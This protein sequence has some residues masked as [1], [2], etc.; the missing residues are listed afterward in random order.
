M[1]LLWF[2]YVQ[3]DEK[4]DGSVMGSLASPEEGSKS[5]HTGDDR[6]DLRFGGNILGSLR[7]TAARLQE[8]NGITPTGELTKT[9][10]PE[11]E[12][13]LAQGLVRI[14]ETVEN[15]MIFF[16]MEGCGGCQTMYPIIKKLQQQEYKIYWVYPRKNQ[17]L[18]RQYKIQKYPTMVIFDNKKVVKK[19]VGPVATKTITNYLNKPQQSSNNS[20]HTDYDFISGLL[21][22]RLW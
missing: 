4:I 5:K 15:Y 12:K 11:R 20:D 13:I 8:Y 2:T 17:K 10:I 3:A 14:P 6:E 19:L 16:T 21:T 9:T 7:R 18:V 1:I 22:Y